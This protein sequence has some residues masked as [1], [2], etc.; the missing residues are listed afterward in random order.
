M[1]L[2]FGPDEDGLVKRARLTED[3][4]VAVSKEHE[5]GTKT[6][7]LERKQGISE[8]MFYNRTAKFGGMGVS[9]AKRLKQLEDENL[10]LNKLLAE[11]R[12]DAAVLR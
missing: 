5:A 9:E 1:K 6:A 7:D 12:L 3:Q 8:A 11:Q 10:K 2:L 4:F